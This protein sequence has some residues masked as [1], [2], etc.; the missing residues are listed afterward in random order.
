M[1][2]W[3]CEKFRISS[4]LLHSSSRYCT[5]IGINARNLNWTWKD[6]RVSKE[7]WNIEL[8]SSIPHVILSTY[9]LQYTEYTHYNFFQ[10]HL[11]ILVA[12]KKKFQ[13]IFSQFS[14]TPMHVFRIIDNI[15]HLIGIC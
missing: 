4:L 14:K 2:N 9:Q 7:R 1:T 15:L 12:S 8:L 3:Y 10:K 13:N 11:E 5:N 6:E